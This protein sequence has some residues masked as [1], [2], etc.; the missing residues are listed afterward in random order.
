M[1]IF[2][3][4]LKSLLSVAL[5]LG[6]ATACDNFFDINTDPNNPL[7]A[8]LSQ[9]LPTAQTVIFEAL[10]NG[11]GGMSDLTSQFVHH[12]VQRGPS[13]FYFFAG[14]EFN[15]SN[16]WPNLYSG[17]LMDLE[18]MIANATERE[19]WHYLGVAQT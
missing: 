17:A 16:A 7:N 11:G 15:I 9:V 6:S 14:N 19:S 1:K 3:Y 12:T 4:K 10:G 2:R 18:T 13:N 8:K 5:V